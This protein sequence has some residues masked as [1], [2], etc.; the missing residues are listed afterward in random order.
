[1][2]RSGAKAKE[3]T[4]EEEGESEAVGSYARTT[5]SPTH[6]HPKKSKAEK[7]MYD[8][9]QKKMDLPTLEE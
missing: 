7:M 1:M 8:Q 2:P 9:R 5:R 6:P 4:G 3:G